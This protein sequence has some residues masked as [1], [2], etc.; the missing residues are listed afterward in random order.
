[1]CIELWTA[2]SRLRRVKRLEQLVMLTDYFDEDDDAAL[3]RL[4]KRLGKRYAAAFI[5]RLARAG[6][7]R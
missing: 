1:M 3:Q 4:L 2:R 7:R 5:F 6:V